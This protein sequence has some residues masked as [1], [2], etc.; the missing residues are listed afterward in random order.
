MTDL[1]AKGE[2]KDESHAGNSSLREEGL[3]EEGLSQAPPAPP[4]FLLLL[5]GQS[6][7]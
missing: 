7:L 1:R 5:M 3:W 6:L 4:A 2:E